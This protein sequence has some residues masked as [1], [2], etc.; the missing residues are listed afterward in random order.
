MT[1][2]KCKSKWELSE[3]WPSFEWKPIDI[4]LSFARETCNTIGVG[5][6]FAT[7][8]IA[9][10]LDLDCI[11]LGFGLH[12]AWIWIA[13]RLGL[14]CISLGFQKLFRWKLAQKVWRIGTQDCAL[15]SKT[16]NS[17][18]YVA[19]DPETQVD[20]GTWWQEAMQQVLWSYIFKYWSQ[21]CVAPFTVE[22]FLGP[23]KY[24]RFV[25]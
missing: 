19:Y 11:S 8:W 12:F 4:C 9:F 2:F 3:F 14:D 5:L 15:V 25:M 20:C 24:T 6:H 16:I 17:Y 10:R 23:L 21:V 1:K 7:S 18:F 22:S 13:F